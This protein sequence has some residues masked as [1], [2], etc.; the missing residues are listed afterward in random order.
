[1]KYIVRILIL[2]S[3]VS[4]VFAQNTEDSTQPL[5]LIANHSLARESSLRAIQELMSTGYVVTGLDY[6]RAFDELEIFYLRNPNEFIPRWTLYEFDDADTLEEEFS[7]LLQEGYRPVDIAVGPQGLIGFFLED[8]DTPLGWRIQ[9]S[10]DFKTIERYTEIY[11][12]IG[13]S[14]HGLSRN[15][16]GE[17][18]ALFARYKTVAHEASFEVIQEDQIG[19]AIVENIASFANIGPMVSQG[20]RFLFSFIIKSIQ[21]ESQ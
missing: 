9:R 10:T 3:I 18:W 14:L 6:N 15:H 16:K 5:W 19:D 7:A 20:S 8:S 4:Y 1:M 2:M 21:T 17:Y 12:R 11:S 13:Y